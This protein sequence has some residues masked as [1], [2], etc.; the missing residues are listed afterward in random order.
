MSSLCILKRACWSCMCLSG[1]PTQGLML[2]SVNSMTRR[3]Q[4]TLLGPSDMRG[5]SKQHPRLGKRQL[6]SWRPAGAHRAVCY[7]W[8]VTVARGRSM[9]KGI[10][11]HL[12]WCWEHGRDCSPWRSPGPVRRER[13]SA[14]KCPFK[15]ACP[16]PEEACCLLFLQDKNICVLWCSSQTTLCGRHCCPF[17]SG[18]EPLPVSP[19][20]RILVHCFQSKP[21]QVPSGIGRSSLR[22]FSKWTP[23][24]YSGP[25][26]ALV[27]G[28]WQ[29]GWKHWMPSELRH[30]LVKC[31]WA[32]SLLGRCLFICNRMTVYHPGCPQRMAVM[33]RWR[34]DVKG[35]PHLGPSCWRGSWFL[36]Q[37]GCTRSC[38]IHSSLLRH[39]AF[40][41]KIRCL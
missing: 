12:P 4:G 22:I 30:K 5:H 25:S 9:V 15:R 16:I 35:L 24:E 26:R 31:P 21:N 18:R 1:P 29:R 41:A 37:G 14:G 39:V 40:P 11:S 33:I 2:T 34:T 23:T 13:E 20:C 7:P 3:F 8:S 6:L 17:P 36:Q 10:S 27:E 19:P 28:Q 38:L 32:G